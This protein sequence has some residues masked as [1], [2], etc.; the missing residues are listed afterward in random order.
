[1]RRTRLLCAIGVSLWSAVV[2][3]NQATRRRCAVRGAAGPREGRAVRD[4][5]VHQRTAAR[6]PRR[7]A[8]VVRQPDPRHRRA[9]SRVSGHRRDR[10]SE[11]ADPPAGRGGVLDRSLPRLLR[12]R[13]HRPHVACGA[14][15]LDAGRDSIRVGRP[16][17]RR[18]GDHSTTFG[19]PSCRDESRAQRRSGSDQQAT[20]LPGRAPSNPVAMLIQDLRY[21]FRSLAKRPGFAAVAVLTLSLGIGATTAIFSVVQAVL[22]RPLEYHGGRPADQDQ[23][24]G[25]SRRR[26][27]EPVAGRLPGLP[28]RCHVVLANGR[29]RLCRPGDRDRRARASPIAWARVQVTEG[30]FPTLQVQPALGRTFLPEE[31]RP[32]GARVAMISDGF[33]RRRYGADPVDCRPVDHRQRRADDRGRRAAGELSPPRDQ[34]RARAPTSSRPTDSIR[35]RRIAAAT[36]FAAWRG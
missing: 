31:D 20:T 5:H 36:S 28:A 29:Q 15:S 10:Q 18:P 6:R 32:G 35:R 11:A 3:G 27:V 22:L 14:V 4:R 30:F 24:P 13:R 25:R 33:W 8:D 23:R 21:A 12:A 16:R 34:S 26:G 17:A 19:T 2:A 1:M 7:A 9:R